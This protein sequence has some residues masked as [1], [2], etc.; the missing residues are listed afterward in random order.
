MRVIVYTD[1]IL[2]NIE[3]AQTLS[4][5]PISLMFKDFYEDTYYEIGAV[6]NKIFGKHIHGS[7]CYSIGEA[8][9]VNC[10]SIV[11]SLDDAK[12]F[13]FREGIRQFYIPINAHDDRE[14]L[15]LSDVR[16]LAHSLSSIAKDVHIHG[17]IT[18]GCLNEK[19]PTI[20]DLRNV[21]DTLRDY[22]E[23]ISLGGGVFGWVKMCNFHH[24]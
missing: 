13:L 2:K 21:W 12:K 14:G 20:E 8:S 16:M 19:H 22:I 5:V 7:T 23:D 9:Y 18:S 15:Q 11:T 24:L 10:A 4:N 6:Y 1:N 17:M 3:K